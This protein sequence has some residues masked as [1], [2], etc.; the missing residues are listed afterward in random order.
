[1]DHQYLPP[2]TRL[3]F[4]ALDAATRMEIQRRSGMHSPNEEI[5]TEC[6][7]FEVRDDVPVEDACHTSIRLLRMVVAQLEVLSID[8]DLDHLH[9]EALKGITCLARMLCGTMGLVHASV[10][11]DLVPAAVRRP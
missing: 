8:P 1:M 2:L 5:R 7:A 6:D 4:A 9:R 11:E 10:C 3:P